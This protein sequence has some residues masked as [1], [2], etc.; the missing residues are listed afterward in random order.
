MPGMEDEA[1]KPIETYGLIGN[2]ET[3]ALVGQDGSIDWC[4]FPHLQSPSL[5]AAL[6]DAEKGGRFRIQPASPFDTVQRYQADT[7]VLETE[8]TTDSGTVVLTDFMP[9]LSDDPAAPFSEPWIY[10]KVEC[11]DGS[12]DV[13]V[14][15]EPRFNY[16]RARTIVESID[17]GVIARGNGEHASLTA[18]FELDTDSES[19]YGR[20]RYDAGDVGWYTLQYGQRRRPTTVDPERLHALTRNYWRNW[21]HDCQGAD[22]PFAGPFHDMITRSELVLKL[23]MHHRTGAIAAAPTTSLPEAIGGTRNWDYRFS[24]IRD[25]AFTIQ[26]LYKLGHFQ[27]TRDYFDWCLDVIHSES[28]TFQPFQPM[29][30]LQGETQLTEETLDHLSGYRGSTPVRIGNAASNQLQLDV[31]GELILALYETSRHQETISETTWETICDVIEYVCTLWDNK[32]AG[33]WEVRSEPEHFVHSKVMCWVALD[34]GI[35]MAGELGF[36]APLEHWKAV[37]SE[38]RTAVLERG[39]NDSL[40][41][42]VRSFEADT[43]L[44]AA[45]LRIPLVGFLPFDDPRVQGTITAIRERLTIDDG[46]VYRYEGADGLPGGEGAFLLCSFWLVDCLAL[47][48]DIEEAEQLFERILEHT[49]PLGLLSEEII[50]ETGEF[51]GNYPQAFSHLGLI[52]SAIY[53]RAAREIEDPLLETDAVMQDVLPYS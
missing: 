10:R 1:Y 25:A 52:N 12:V 19:A 35:K 27:E 39:F 30:G 22:C 33:M 38:I 14:D 37:R 45:A 21:I 26:A 3:C 15:F 40:N 46:L 42:F 24:W 2:L 23:L 17:D 6:L 20:H 44:D 50:P 29:F 16:A 34:R 43:L 7:N 53:L 9:M 8:F 41:S 11:L 5:F 31:F 4:C 28:E 18:T 48:G 32:G 49:S 36:D 51:L 13:D 47:S